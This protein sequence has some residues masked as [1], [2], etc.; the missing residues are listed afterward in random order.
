MLLSFSDRNKVFTIPGDVLGSDL[1]YL[2]E[3]FRES[4]CFE[5]NV[6]IDISTVRI[7]RNMWKSVKMKLFLTRTS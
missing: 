3:K 2:E 4:F 7:G 1:T 5:N 6:S